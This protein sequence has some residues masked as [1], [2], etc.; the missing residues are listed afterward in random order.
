[1]DLLLV[2]VCI[3]MVGWHSSAECVSCILKGRQCL[4][5]KKFIGGPMRKKDLRFC[6]S[7]MTY[8]PHWLVHVNGLTLYIRYNGVKV[9]QTEQ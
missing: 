2:S 8:D 1:M 7:G 9:S 6:K 3:L 5:C 4:L